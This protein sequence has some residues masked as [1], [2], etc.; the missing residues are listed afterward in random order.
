MCTSLFIIV[1]QTSDTGNPLLTQLQASPKTHTRG[2]VAAP[3]A[4]AAESNS[5]GWLDTYHSLHASRMMGA[6]SSRIDSQ[7]PSV[8]GQPARSTPLLHIYNTLRI[9][10]RRHLLFTTKP[11]YI[12]TRTSK[13]FK[14]IHRHTG[15]QR[16]TLTALGKSQQNTQLQI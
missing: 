4:V 5:V 6:E 11:T 13:A 8:G 16:C 12:H 1:I 15:T 9:H 7:G 3:V 2:G 10:I 14:S